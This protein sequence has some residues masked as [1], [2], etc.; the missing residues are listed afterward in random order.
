L[1]R[2]LRLDQL[3]RNLV[4]QLWLDLYA[5]PVSAIVAF[6]LRQGGEDVEDEL[7]PGVVVSIA[8]GGSATR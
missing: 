8:P 1:K 2:S 4:L 7:A 6:E 3:P 5:K